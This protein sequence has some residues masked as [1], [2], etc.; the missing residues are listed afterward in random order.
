MRKH[1]RPVYSMTIAQRLFRFVSYH[2]SEAV[3]NLLLAIVN[4]S[5]ARRQLKYHHSNEQGSGPE[6]TRVSTRKKLLRVLSLCLAHNG[7]FS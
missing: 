5:G 1:L 4:Y 6:L 7:P 3:Y 2:L